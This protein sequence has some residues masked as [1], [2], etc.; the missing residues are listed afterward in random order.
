MESDQKKEI[1]VQ[2]ITQSSHRTAFQSGNYDSA[3]LHYARRFLMR[4]ALL[5]LCL[6]GSAFI[7]PAGAAPI[8]WTNTS[9]GS[10]NVAA[11]WS[12]NSVPGASDDVFITSNGTYTVIMNV[13]PTISNLTLGG[14]SGQQTLTNTSQTLTLS[15]ASVVNTN[16]VLGMNGGVLNGLGSLSINGQVHWNGGSSGNGFSVT[17]QSNAV[18]NLQAQVIFAGAVTNFGTV[19]WLAGGVYLN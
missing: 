18:L 14:V 1:I 2:N 19:N 13:S 7:F 16:G 17:V 15:L 4:T 8:T 9:G 12:P 3:I 6:F 11:N 10:W 5:G